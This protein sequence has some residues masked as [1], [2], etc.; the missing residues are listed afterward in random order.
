MLPLDRGSPAPPAGPEIW[1]RRLKAEQVVDFACCS[2]SVWEFWIHWDQ[3][4]RKSMPCLKDHSVC[5]GHRLELP[6]KWRGYLYGI[7]HHTRK[8]EF[9]EVTPYGVE[10]LNAMVGD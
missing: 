6:R 3:D 7:N 9:L 5:P 4:G 2:P 1:V 8:M 10:Q